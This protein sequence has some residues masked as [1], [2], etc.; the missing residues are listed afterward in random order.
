LPPITYF[1][2]IIT[3]PSGVEAVYDTPIVSP[4]DVGD[5][6]PWGIIGAILSQDY[7]N[8]EARSSSL[9]IGRKAN[10]LALKKYRYPKK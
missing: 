7:I 1:P 2:L 4:K 3:V 10:D 5:P 8:T 9:A 6:L